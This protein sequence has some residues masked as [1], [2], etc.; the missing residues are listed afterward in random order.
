MA[1]ATPFLDTYKEHVRQKR[2][3]D[4]EVS[5]A[6]DLIMKE[7]DHDQ[8]FARFLELPKHVQK[9]I[10]CGGDGASELTDHPTA[11]D[12]ILEEFWKRYDQA[13]I[14]FDDDDSDC[15]SSKSGGSGFSERS[16][17]TLRSIARRQD[18]EAHDYRRQVKD[19]QHERE[20][21]QASLE[22]VILQ[23]RPDFV[24]LLPQP[25]DIEAW[26]TLITK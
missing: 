3:R 9:K 7:S 19:L 18:Q 4:N 5:D 12:E 25:S 14:V 24:D 2:A 26:E 16:W 15:E 10:F 6:V 22:Y 13:K 8:R 11:T 20:V 23:R 21:L 17:K 1:A